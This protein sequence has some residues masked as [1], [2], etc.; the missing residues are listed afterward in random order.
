MK[1]EKRRYRV[2]TFL[3]REELDFLDEVTK[4]IYFSKGVNIPRTKLIEELI[5]A[6]HDKDKKEVEEIVLNKHSKQAAI[7]KKEIIR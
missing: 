2:V 5:E 3:S 7:I 4:D 1:N 6:F